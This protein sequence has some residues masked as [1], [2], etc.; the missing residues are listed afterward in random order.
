MRAV[1]RTDTVSLLVPAL[2]VVALTVGIAAVQAWWTGRRGSV[3][4]LRVGD[5]R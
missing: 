1:L 4:E 5:A 2:A 3:R